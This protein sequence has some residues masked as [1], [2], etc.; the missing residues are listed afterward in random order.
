MISKIKNNCEG[1]EYINLDKITQI[2]PVEDNGSVTHYEVYIGHNLIRAHKD[3]AAISSM[4]ST[5]D[6]DY[7]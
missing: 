6:T 1:F 5:A 7:G 4:I 2:D 3:E